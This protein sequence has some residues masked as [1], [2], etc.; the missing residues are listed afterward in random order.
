MKS[1][2]YGSRHGFGGYARQLFPRAERA[3]LVGYLILGV[4]IPTLYLVGG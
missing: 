1:K 3:L 2:V 4:L